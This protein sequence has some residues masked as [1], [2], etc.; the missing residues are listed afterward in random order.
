[1]HAPINKPS[2]PN[3]SQVKLVNQFVTSPSI[4]TNFM[5]LKFRLTNLKMV[6]LSPFTLPNQMS[7]TK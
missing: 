4:T 5:K 3:I 2:S 6:Q 1:L 7:P